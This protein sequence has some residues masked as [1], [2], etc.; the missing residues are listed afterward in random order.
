MKE[1]ME[2]RKRATM[3]C[4]SPALTK[5]GKSVVGHKLGTISVKDRKFGPHT[6]YI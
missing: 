5:A 6:I 2:R 4:Y 3:V 1:A